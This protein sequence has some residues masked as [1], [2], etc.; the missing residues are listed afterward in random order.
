MT[1]DEVRKALPEMIMFAKNDE[2]RAH[3]KRL[4]NL[5]TN[6]EFNE[7]VR[8]HSRPISPSPSNLKKTKA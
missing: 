7:E 8:N 2:D 3:Y 5:D 6:E 4:L 1:R